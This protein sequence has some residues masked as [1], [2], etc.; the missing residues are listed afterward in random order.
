MATISRF[1]AV[2]KMGNVEI[3]GF[4]GWVLWL[5]VHVMFLVGFR[6]RITSIV[7]WGINALSRNRWNLAATRQQLYARAAM[8][9]VDEET[10]TLIPYC[11]R[12]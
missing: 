11:P 1:N 6:N 8:H 7:S 10:R 3:T 12:P 2:V 5:V 4:F 9:E